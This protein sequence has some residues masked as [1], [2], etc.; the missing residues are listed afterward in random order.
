MMN[1]GHQLLNRL[2]FTTALLM[3]GHFAH[4]QFTIMPSSYITIREGSTLRIGTDLYINSN[5]T[6]SG[7]LVDRT[8]D[9]DVVIAGDITV[10]RYM[11]A[12]YWHNTS[13]PVST[14]NSS[15]Y[16]GTE[17]V[18]YYDETLIINDWMFGWVMYSGA[19]SVMKGYDVYFDQN[20]VTVLYTATGTQTINTGSFNSPVTI[21]YWD[22]GE[23][24]P[25]R[26]W[27]LLGNPYPSPVDWQVSSGWDKSDINDA[28]YIWDGPNDNYTIWIGGGSP[29]GINGGTR[30]IPS[31][32]GFWVQAVQNGSVQV[33]NSSRIGETPATPDYYKNKTIGYP[34]LDLMAHANGLTDECM[35]RFLDG[36]SEAFDLNYDAT[37]LFSQGN[38]V[39]QIATM[40]E[41]INLAIN[42]LP[43][44]KDELMVPLS[45]QCK[46]AGYYTIGL[47]DVTN[48]D[49]FVKVY[50]K[51]E[52]EQKTI[53]LSA[54]LSYRFYHDPMNRKNRFKIYFNP[55]E[56]VINNIGPED[57]FSVFANRGG[58]SILKNTNKLLTGRIWV[59]NTLGQPVYS[60][61]LSSNSEMLLK[62]M[63]ASGYYY[64]S[65]ITPQQISNHKIFISN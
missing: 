8:V 17:L 22:N 38:E 65:I 52:L 18:F 27:N 6:A 64:V 54:N 56:D 2:L 43:E 47:T 40:S 58:I 45:F 21:S 61:E 57:Y 50:L 7:Y 32:Q 46:K 63:L 55:S 36:A 30:Y 15:V 25:H 4:A 16:P 26:G 37:K 48:L 1:F 23:V 33:T 49:A 10:E 53:D 42:S 35:I 28:K 34:V 44:L 11:S 51:D 39:P 9:G 12:N 59:Y 20:P 13:S 60:T 19:L 41:N 24:D 29:I 62:L 5:A 14:A 3:C 31:N